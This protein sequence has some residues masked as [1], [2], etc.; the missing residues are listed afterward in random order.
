MVQI[1]NIR[2]YITSSHFAYIIHECLY[3]TYH[4]PQLTMTLFIQLYT[5]RIPLTNHGD[6][7]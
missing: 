7:P 5:H 6:N 4:T 3:D 1:L 2:E